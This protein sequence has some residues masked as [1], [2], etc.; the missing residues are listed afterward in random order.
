MKNR[1]LG[2]IKS[3]NVL[4]IDK[5]KILWYNIY[6]IKKGSDCVSKYPG[7][8]HN[9]TDYSNETL[10]D[11]INKVNSLIDT[12]IDLGHDCVAITDH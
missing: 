1:W 3:M 6:R 4:I 5:N 12:A 9:H 2:I 8:L 10:R 11:C 7:S